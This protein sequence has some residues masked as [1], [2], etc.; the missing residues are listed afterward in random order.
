MLPTAGSTVANFHLPCV[1][2]YYDGSQVYLLPSCITAALTL[3]NL[4][5]KYFAGSNDPI[6][7]LNKYRLRGYSIALNDSE[8]IRFISYSSKVEKWNNL[9]GGINIKDKNSVNSVYGYRHPDSIFFNPRY[10]LKEKF[11]NIKPA[12]MQACGHGVP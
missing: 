9:Y 10:I 12:R 2:G 11:N 8:K 5:Y 7:I 4:D 1:R 6:E 3:I